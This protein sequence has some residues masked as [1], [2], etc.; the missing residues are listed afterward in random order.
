[1]NYREGLFG[2][3]GAELALPL[4]KQ[5]KTSPPLTLPRIVIPFH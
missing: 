3:Y 2:K 1:V 5:N 4:N